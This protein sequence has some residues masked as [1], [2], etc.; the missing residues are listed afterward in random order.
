MEIIIPERIAL[1]LKQV[2]AF[3]WRVHIHI[4]IATLMLNATLMAGIDRQYGRGMLYVI[5]W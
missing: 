4:I 5:S 2:Q 3:M 1:L